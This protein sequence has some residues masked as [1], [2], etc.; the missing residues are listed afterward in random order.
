MRLA[1]L[2]SMIK[3]IEC[4]FGEILPLLWWRITPSGSNFSWGWGGEGGGQRHHK[5]WT[6]ILVLKGDGS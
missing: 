1:H 5:M 3:L 2:I 4:R 6:E